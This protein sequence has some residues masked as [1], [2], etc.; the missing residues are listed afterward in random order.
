[1]EN[2]AERKSNSYR[3]H[4]QAIDFLAETVFE[5]NFWEESSS[6]KL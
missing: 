2:W 5:K 3:D 6:H 1:M 4:V